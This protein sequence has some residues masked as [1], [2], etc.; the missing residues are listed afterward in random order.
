MEPG[1]PPLVVGVVDVVAAAGTRTDRDC[2]GAAKLQDGS[3]LDGVLP[4]G[5]PPRGAQL[6]RREADAGGGSAVGDVRR[7]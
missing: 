2:G 6:P 1:T 7:R 5:P 3:H 4:E